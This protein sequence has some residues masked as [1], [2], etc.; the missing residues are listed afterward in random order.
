MAKNK[1]EKA[2]KKLLPNRY[3]SK[4]QAAKLMSCYN[5]VLIGPFSGM[6]YLKQSIGSKLFPKLLGTYEKEL[7]QVVQEIN[8]RQYKLILNIGAA[9]GYYAVGLTMK[10]P[11]SQVIAFESEE[12]GQQYIIQLSL[13][14]NISDRVSVRGQCTISDLCDSIKPET[15][16]FMDVEGEEKSLLDLDACPKLCRADVLVEVHEHLSPGIRTLLK[17]RFESTHK[18]KVIQSSKRSMNDLPVRIELDWDQSLVNL[19]TFGKFQKKIIHRL[20]NEYRKQPVC[21]YYMTR[22]PHLK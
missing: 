6:K 1:F 5:K 15:L 7:H 21:W 16:I 12:S 4:A 20:V 18:I 10:N 14:N 13:I 19:L 9:E 17:S 8:S 22:L 3:S 11:Q 2:I